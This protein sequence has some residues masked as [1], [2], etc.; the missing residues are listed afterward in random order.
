MLVLGILDL[1]EV[2]PEIAEE[3]QLSLGEEQLLLV[4]KILGQGSLKPL[5]HCADVHR[6]GVDQQVQL[7]KIQLGVGGVSLQSATEDLSGLLG[8]RQPPGEASGIWR[9]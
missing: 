9:T 1:G 6:A 7:L 8:V 2:S 4:G 3:L 5:S